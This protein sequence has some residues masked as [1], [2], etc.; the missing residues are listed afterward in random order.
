M[1]FHILNLLGISKEQVLNAFIEKNP[2]LS[3]YQEFTTSIY[4][5]FDKSFYVYITK[6]SVEIMIQNETVKP[7][8]MNNHDNFYPVTFNIK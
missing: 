1:S 7:D 8:F 2:Y 4:E 3:N 6:D 5:E